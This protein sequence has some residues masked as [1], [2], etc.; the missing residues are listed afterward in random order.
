VVIQTSDIYKAGGG[1]RRVRPNVGSPYGEC[2]G[3]NFQLGSSCKS[4]ILFLLTLIQF[5]VN[6]PLHLLNMFCS[7]V[8]GTYHL[9]KYYSW[10]DI[11]IVLSEE[12][13]TGSTNK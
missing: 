7:H 12:I 13:I 2:L 10:T 11:K 3:I 8:T 4:E 9:D 6:L 1:R 5:L